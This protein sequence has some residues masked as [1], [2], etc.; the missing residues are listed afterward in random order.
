MGLPDELRK[1]LFYRGIIFSVICSIVRL[2]IDKGFSDFVEMFSLSFFISEYAHFDWRLW[3][4]CICSHA[5]DTFISLFFA[6]FFKIGGRKSSPQMER[7]QPNFANCA[8]VCSRISPKCS[9]FAVECHKNSKISYNVQKLGFQKNRWI[10][11]KKLEFF[12]ITKGG[13]FAID[14]LLNG[15]TCQNVF[16]ALIL[17]FF[18][19]K[20]R[21]LLKLKKLEN[22][23]NKECFFRKKNALVFLKAFSTK[24]R[25]WKKC[26]W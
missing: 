23:M 25:R 8:H 16:S 14:C 13:K 21:K 20:V 1:L 19:Q 17:T 10:F 12:K 15:I 18:R 24:L 6:I 7:F 2:W 4:H 5:V 26:R 3:N 22:M 11:K 9:I